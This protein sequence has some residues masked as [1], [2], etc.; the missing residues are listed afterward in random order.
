MVQIAHASID[1][2]GRI[3]G[4]K[5]GDQTG[6]ELCIRDW[7]NAGWNTVIRIDDDKKARKLANKMRNAVN[8]PN[9]GYD[10]T[11]RLSFYYEMKANGFHPKRIENACETDCSALVAACANAVGVPVIPSMTTYNEVEQFSKCGVP[12]YILKDKSYTADYK[13]LR[14]GD[15]LVSGGHT[16]VVVSDG[17]EAVWRG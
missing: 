12:C 7:Y 14:E 17:S 13:K 10:Q 3:S 6:R 8:N 1:E 9:I 11:N 2:R 4:G 15:I 5:A 16:A